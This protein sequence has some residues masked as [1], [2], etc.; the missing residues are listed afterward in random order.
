MQRVYPIFIVKSPSAWET[1]RRYV[2]SGVP[3]TQRFRWASLRRSALRETS[4][5][6]EQTLLK[7][8]FV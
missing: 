3:T 8:A 6:L 2:I 7:Q 5:V 1:G 4:A